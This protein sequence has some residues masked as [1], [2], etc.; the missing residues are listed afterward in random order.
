[1]LAQNAS[2]LPASEAAN[3]DD[4]ALLDV[5][6]AI[7]ATGTSISGTIQS[8]DPQ[9][10]L[11]GLTV[12]ATNQT[13]RDIF[14]TQTLNDGSFLLDSVTPARPRTQADARARG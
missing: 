12:M 11:A 4:D 1:M 6:R 9:L 10:G 14:S 7:A 8:T 5:D 3:P 13:T 2:L